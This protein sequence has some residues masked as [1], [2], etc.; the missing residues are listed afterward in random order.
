MLYLDSSP[1]GF[2][3]PQC[4]QLNLQFYEVMLMDLII[5]LEP[6]HC[7]ALSAVEFVEFY[8]D[9]YYERACGGLHVGRDAKFRLFSRSYAP[10]TPGKTALITTTNRYPNHSKGRRSEPDHCPGRLGLAASSP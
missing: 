9:C 10:V 1:P 3:V 6:E 4:L 7:N 2:R 8:Y 5:Y